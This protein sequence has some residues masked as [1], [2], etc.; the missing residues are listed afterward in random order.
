MRTNSYPAN[1][2]VCGRRVAAHAGYLS[3][4]RGNWKVRHRTC[5]SVPARSPRRPT[6]SSPP[7]KNGSSAFGWKVAAVT[8]AIAGIWWL[9]SAGDPTPPQPE[10]ATFAYGDYVIELT[11]G[12]VSRIHGPVEQSIPE[13]LGGRTGAICRDGWRSSAT[14]SGA[15]SW[16]GGVSK[17]VRAIKEPARTEIVTADLCQGSGSG[18]SSLAFQ[19]TRWSLPHCW[20]WHLESYESNAA[21]KLAFPTSE[22]AALLTESGFGDV[23]ATGD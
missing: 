2:T 4:S 6:Q 5:P 8:A 21:L 22:Y 1:C 12:T 14:G 10:L 17:W 15:C 3:G 7:S 19:Y 20:N 18:P 9:T 23:P 11:D 13:V 16:H